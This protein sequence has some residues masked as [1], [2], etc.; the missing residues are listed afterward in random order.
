[1]N[2]YYVPIILTF[3]MCTLALIHIIAH[4]LLLPFNRETKDHKDPLYSHTV[5]KCTLN[6]I[7]LI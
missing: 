7:M 5:S 1:M 2:N 4:A 3:T 6:I